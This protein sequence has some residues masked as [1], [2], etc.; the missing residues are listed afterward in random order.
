MEDFRLV[1]EQLKDRLE[2]FFKGMGA[3][4]GITPEVQTTLDRICSQTT[5]VVAAANQILRDV[6]GSELPEADAANL[7][8][9][10][11]QVEHARLEAASAE[12]KLM[13]LLE[14]NAKPR[15]TGGRKK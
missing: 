11:R 14:K 12:K 3:G 1:A 5:D 9:L 6:P 10:A 8:S 13:S 15:R 2:V 4:S 7:D